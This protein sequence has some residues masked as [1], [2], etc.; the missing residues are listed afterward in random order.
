[1]KPARVSGG[2]RL[3][4]EIFRYNPEDPRSTPHMQD[5]ELDDAPYMSLFLALNMIREQQDPSLQFD[6]ACRSAIC[7]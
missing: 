5:F 2:R 7:G 6:F 4:F 3:R 1:M